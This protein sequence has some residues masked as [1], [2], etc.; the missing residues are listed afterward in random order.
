MRAIIIATGQS[1]DINLSEKLPIPML[2]VIDR[3]FIQHVVEYLV[4]KGFATFDFA[5]SHMPEKLEELLGDGQRWGSKFRFHLVRDPAHP[6]RIFKFLR[7]DEAQAPVLLGHA[8]RLP[9]MDFSQAWFRSVE[10]PIVFGHGDSTRQYWTGWALFPNSTGILCDSE[11]D[12][13]QMGTHLLALARDRGRVVEVPEVI[14]IRTW[15]NFLE[16]HEQILDKNFPGLMLKGREIDPGIWI[17][18]NVMIKPGCRLIPPVYIGENSQ[19]NQR[20]TLGPHA[21]VGAG[22]IIEQDSSVSNSVIFPQSYVGEGLDVA[23][24]AVDKNRLVN[25]R[26]G[27]SILIDDEFIL[28]SLSKNV[29]RRW[30]LKTVSR[31]TAMSLLLVL[32][33]LWLLTFAW[34]KIKRRGGEVIY[35]KEIVRIPTSSRPQEWR[36]FLLPRFCPAGM[37]LGMRHFLLQFVPALPHI[38]R[39]DLRF[40]GVP[41]RTAEEIRSLPEDWKALY[42]NTKSGMITEAEVDSSREDH[43]ACEAFY[44]AFA[45][46][47]YDLKLTLRYLFRVLS[48]W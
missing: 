12:E 43:Y 38:A 32:W 33:P 36:T 26:L 21:V 5:L 22:C 29:V 7:D 34:L 45:G 41:T 31:L 30:L 1:P 25:M 13:E 17:S 24:S 15:E 40:V 10:T 9:R 18:R 19:I 6:Y 16:A 35:R 2:P 14:D 48:R 4:E 11:Y 37:R 42:L 28:G 44:S 20:V 3:P 39:G 47:K 8:D 46:F 23:E 27:S